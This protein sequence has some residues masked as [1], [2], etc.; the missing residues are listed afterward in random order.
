M[1]SF[2]VFDSTPESRQA[3]RQQLAEQVMEWLA[4]GHKITTIPFGQSKYTPKPQVNRATKTKREKKAEETAR[5]ATL[6]EIPTFIT[7]HCKESA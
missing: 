1:D 2:P 3:E 4:S 7:H 5:A 6:A